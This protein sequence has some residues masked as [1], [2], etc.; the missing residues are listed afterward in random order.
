MQVVVLGRDARIPTG[1][2][3]RRLGGR[4]S[5]FAGTAENYR[6]FRVGLP[7]GAVHI[8]LEHVTAPAG[9]RRLLDLGTGTGLV[10]RALLDHFD[11]VVAVDPDPDLLDVAARELAG[12]QGETPRV[13][14]I[15]STA[16]EF[17]APRGWAADLVTICRAFHWMDQARVLRQLDSCVSPQGA[18]AVLG[19]A[20]FWTSRTSWKVAMR[21][22][23]QEFLGPNKRAGSGTFQHHARPYRELLEESAFSVVEERQLR[24]VTRRTIDSVIGYLHSTSFAAPGLFGARLHEF[25]DTAR[26]R[27]AALSEGGAVEDDDEFHVLVAHRPPGRVRTNS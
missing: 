8:L 24:V 5:L 15:R 6:R 10:V 12:R 17:E 19:E 23:V 20:G 4:V 25:D 18:V 7:D 21:E 11:D 14:L 27:L 13:R 16:E 1:G 2:G 3:S 22:L 26:A 9:A